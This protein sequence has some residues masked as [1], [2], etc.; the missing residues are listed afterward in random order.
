[1]Q[2]NNCLFGHEERFYRKKPDHHCYIGKKVPKPLDGKG[3]FNNCTCQR[4]D[5]ECDYNYQPTKDGR[6]ELVPGETP[7]DHSEACKNDPNLIEWFKPTGYRRIPLTTCQGG[8]ELDK[9]DSQPCPGREPAYKKKHGGMSGAAIFFLTLGVFG[10][11]GAIGYIIWKRWQGK[12]GQ[13]RLGDDPQTGGASKIADTAMEYGVLVVSAVV[14]VVAALP[15]IVVALY[16]ATVG[17]F[18]QRRP[19]FTTRGSFARG[20]YSAVTSDEGELLGD[21]SDE[22]V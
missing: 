11:A 10:M 18:F 7:P 3:K 16:G 8:H 12:F 22:E 20:D 5:Y 15:S 9:I 4:Q 19:R 14:A 6:C 1:M 13:I 2:D 21:E 17:R